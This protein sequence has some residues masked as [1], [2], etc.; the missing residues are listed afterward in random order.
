MRVQGTAFPPRSSIRYEAELDVSQSNCL[1]LHVNG[2]IFSCQQQDVEISVPVGNLPIRFIFPSGWMFVAE[3]TD[4]V[5]QWLKRNS[6]SG[7]ADKLE[8]SIIA[9]FIGLVVSI[10]VLLGG[11]YYALPWGSE[12]VAKLIPSSISVSLGNKVLEAFESRWLP[13]ELPEKQQEVI[14]QRVSQHLQQLEALPYTIEILFRS[15]DMGANAFALPGGKVVLLDELIELAE[16]DQQLD[17]IILHELG[18]VY[19]RHMMEK[20]VHSSL[21]SVGVVMLF[22][23]SSGIVDNLVSIGVFIISNG[24]SRM[25]ESEA[26]EYAKQAMIQLYGSS[27]P[28]AEMF[29]LFQK[30]DTVDIPSWLSSHPDSE[31]RIKSARE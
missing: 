8:S 26:D 14:R 22:G 6:K 20:L 17:S 19:H 5:S 25:A 24:H 23:E 16:N 1:S 21:I 7:R 15:S 3:R 29:E 13:S 10:S 12:K 28:M 30:Q 31:Q 11:Y 18:H 2:D 9:W 4:E 27:E